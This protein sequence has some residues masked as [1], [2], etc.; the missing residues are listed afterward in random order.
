MHHRLRREQQHHHRRDRH[1][2]QRQNRPVEHYPDQH[3]RYHDEGP[4]RRDLRTGQNQ[5]K[6]GNDQRCQ[7]RPL[8]DRPAV[9]KPGDQRQQGTHHKEHDARDDRHVIAGDRQHVPDAGHEHCIEHGGRDRV[10]LA[11]D[12]GGSNRAN[13]ARQH[14]ADA[15]VDAVANALNERIGAHRQTRRRGRGH[16][17]DRAVHEPRSAD[18]LEIQIAR[19][20]VPARPQ[21]LQ[22]RTE[23]SLEFDEG[24]RG[25]RH[26]AAHRKPHP[27]RLLRQAV[28]FDAVDPHDETVGLLTL[29][30]K[31]DEPRQRHAIGRMVQHRVVYQRGLERGNGEA[32]GD[33]HKPETNDK[34]D[35]SPPQQRGHHDG[36]NR[37]CRG[38]PDRWL[39]FGGEIEDDPEAEADRKPRQQAAGSGLDGR[40]LA[41]PRRNCEFGPRPCRRS[42]L[43]CTTDRPGSCPCRRTAT[44]PTLVRHRAPPT[45]G[46]GPL[47][48]KKSPSC[49]LDARA[50]ASDMAIMPTHSKAEARSTPAGGAPPGT[51]RQKIEE[52]SNE[53]TGL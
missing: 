25:R 45:K 4:L 35:R 16:D 52:T 14:R 50:M 12:E 32:A 29:L 30:A 48:A 40:P 8:F 42:I 9:G 13:V 7:C 20:I 2:A 36:G 5:I 22:R 6:G 38:S 46:T 1:G 26:A 28:R 41:K 47:R 44:R 39:V 31:L 17:P 18:A 51:E 37:Q 11:G 3:D 27:L 23:L 33:R 53:R 24:P 15:Q 10:A 43:T 19:E 34:A 49:Y 21:R